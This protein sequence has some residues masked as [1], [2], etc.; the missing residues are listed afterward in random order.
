MLDRLKLSLRL[1]KQF[2]RP[3]HKRSSSFRRYSDRKLLEI[4]KQLKSL[5]EE[6]ELRRAAPEA[7]EAFHVNPPSAKFL[8]RV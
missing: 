5:S 3:Y 2:N 1:G 8:A 7:Y 6:G 4:Y